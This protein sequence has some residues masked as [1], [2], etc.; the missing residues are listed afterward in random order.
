MKYLPVSETREPNFV[1]SRRVPR[2]LQEPDYYTEVIKQYAQ[3]ILSTL[4][5]SEKKILLTYATDFLHIDNAQRDYRDTCQLNTPAW[6][7][8]VSE[9]ELWIYKESSR[10][11]AR[12]IAT[13]WISNDF[14]TYSIVKKEIIY[15]IDHICNYHE[16]S[17]SYKPH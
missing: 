16:Y 4:T 11:I 5:S 9:S 12:A 6:L 17:G 14:Q 3:K 15:W 7:I 2:K 10:I 8:H 1:C 13:L